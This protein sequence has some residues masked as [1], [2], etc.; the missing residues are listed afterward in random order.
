MRAGMRSRNRKLRSFSPSVNQMP[1]EQDKGLGSQW[2]LPYT[3]LV[4]EAPGCLQ[5]TRNGGE[6]I[7]TGENKCGKVGH[8]E[9]EC[10][11]HFNDNLG[12]GIKGSIFHWHLMRAF[13]D[14]SYGGRNHISFWSGEFLGRNQGEGRILS[15]TFW[16]K[17]KLQW[18]F[19]IG[20]E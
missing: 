20:K 1:L 19:R 9:K 14:S 15:S 3:F 12:K 4:A 7:R 18:I 16:K 10:L 13:N 8:F 17:K 11:I 5:Q 6:M 2:C